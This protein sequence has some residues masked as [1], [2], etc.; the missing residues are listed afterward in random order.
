MI[1]KVSLYFVLPMCI[2]S[3][4]L[5]VVG[6]QHVQ[7][8][9]SYYSFIG[10]VAS[11]FETWKLTIPDI[12]LIDNQNFTMGDT[13]SNFLKAIANILNFF[14]LVINGLI[15]IINLLISVINIVIQMIQFIFT[16]IY[17]CKDFIEQLRNQG[18]AI[19]YV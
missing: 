4:F 18:V 6:V 10:N 2:I 1:Q 13:D 8:G 17:S 7:L 3:F 16:L 11:R 9:E 12:P 19:S 14:V 15:K 5:A